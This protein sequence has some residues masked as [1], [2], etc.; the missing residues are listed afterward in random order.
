MLLD[1][2]CHWS[3][4]ALLGVRII[5]RYNNI[6]VKS[7]TSPS[8]PLMVTRYTTVTLPLS[9][10][11]TSRTSPHQPEKKNSKK[12]EESED[13]N[14]D[15]KDIPSVKLPW[16]ETRVRLQYKKFYHVKENQKEKKN[17]IT[18]CKSELERLHGTT[19]PYRKGDNYRLSADRQLFKVQFHMQGIKD[20]RKRIH[21]KEKNTLPLLAS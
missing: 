20:K 8:E 17:S 4:I 21:I 18:K 6:R 3:L 12:S 5:S 13:C 2:S 16:G 9:E 11:I 7:H 19:I 14:D 10:K 15:N 1:Q